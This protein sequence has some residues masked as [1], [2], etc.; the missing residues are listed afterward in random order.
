[1]SVIEKKQTS[2]DLVSTASKVSLELA[3]I[4]I[5]GEDIKNLFCPNANE[6]EVRIALGIVQSLKLNPFTREVH[7]IK[8]D[9]NAKMAIVVGYEVYLKR[10]ERTGK[11][12]GWRAGISEDG[13]K[14]FVEIHRKDW[15]TPFYWEVMLSEFTKNQATWKSMPTFMGIKVAI[16][17]GFRLCFADELGGMPYTK[18]EHDVFDVVGQEVKSKKPANVREPEAITHK[19]PGPDP[20]PQAEE[21]AIDKIL[22]EQHQALNAL[23]VKAFSGKSKAMKEFLLF[24]YEVEKISELKS[25]QIAECAVKL[26]DLIKKNK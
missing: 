25:D 18:D 4:K 6:K 7:F 15:K 8:Y 11:L 2:K 12:D 17:Q 9:A 23:A 10:A 13:L 24:T 22:S 19:E 20:D 16:A 1:M 26:N 5:T 21:V 14:S 3:P